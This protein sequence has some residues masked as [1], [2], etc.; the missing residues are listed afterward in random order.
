[1]SLLL[2]ALHKAAKNREGGPEQEAEDDAVSHELAP[3]ERG[4]RGPALGEL[5][6]DPDALSLADEEE[7]CQP[8]PEDEEPALMP[9]PE[10]ALA[11]ARPPERPV[12]RPANASG[13]SGHAATILRANETRST[14]ALDWVR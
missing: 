10:P 14:G 9:A 6:A 4:P 5:P 2:Q 3:D 13:G 12:L 7:L 1:M 11:P 8:E